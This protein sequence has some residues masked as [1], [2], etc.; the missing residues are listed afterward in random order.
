MCGRP[1]CSAQH[2]SLSFVEESCCALTL[3]GVTC[4][5]ALL[6]ISEICTYV[7]TIS[8]IHV[9]HVTYT[10]IYIVASGHYWPTN[11]GQLKPI[12]KKKRSVIYVKNR[13]T[14]CDQ[15]WPQISTPRKSNISLYLLQKRHFR[16]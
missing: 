8:V 14:K 16:C 11:A 15:K 12:V 9:I 6:H 3:V 13:Q 1:T 4:S 7:I 10:C 5:T 2:D